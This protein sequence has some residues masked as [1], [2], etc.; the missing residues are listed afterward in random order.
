MYCN[1][2]RSVLPGAVVPPPL[3]RATPTRKCIATSSLAAR[4]KPR[5]RAGQSV[6]ILQSK[7][8]VR[9][10]SGSF[11]ASEVCGGGVV[12]DALQAGDSGGRHHN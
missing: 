6:G 3:P 8:A 10:G 1:A 9:G 5:L 12:G 4:R 2:D 7:L 11:S